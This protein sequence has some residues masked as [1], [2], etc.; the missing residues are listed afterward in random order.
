MI[1]L[2]LVAAATVASPVQLVVDVLGGARSAPE[3][4]T[5][6]PT[7]V[8]STGPAS[9]LAALRM[10]AESSEARGGW[11]GLSAEAWF[12]F[13]DP[14]PSLLRAEPRI[15]WSPKFGRIWH[16]DLA[17]RYAAEVTPWLAEYGN[18][19]AEATGR[20]GPTL[21][22][23]VLDA[24]L[25]TTR[26]DYF[27][28]RDWSFQT[29]DGG[30]RVSLA[31]MVPTIRAAVEALGQG[32]A[33]STLDSAG[34]AHPATGSQVQLR[35]D[36]G[37]EVRGFDLSVSW[38]L[39]HAWEG[40]V[41]NAARPQFTPIGQYA[42]D[43]DALSAGGFLQHRFEVSALWTPSSSWTFGFD[44]LA[45]LRSSDAGQ[46]SATWARTLHGQL[47][48]ERALRGPL[49]LLM[50]GGVTNVLLVDGGAATDVYGWVGLRWRPP[51]PPD[52]A[53][54]DE[55]RGTQDPNQREPAS[56]SPTSSR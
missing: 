20:F 17:A 11:L 55:P 51:P 27:R 14:S 16:A 50:T 45:R 7:A 40:D 13:A 52:R 6:A 37:L 33:G 39:R 44:G 54:V 46:E 25:G 18:G 23:I 43:A 8:D 49:S 15:G 2:A 47:R 29:I 48:V 19:R 42:D 36:V 21:G 22:P 24:S 30:L 26:R 38:R 5:E 28:R 1:S 35:V 31:P 10:D 34:V 12:Y 41:E 56:S 4:T 3:I 53:D 32:N 9:G